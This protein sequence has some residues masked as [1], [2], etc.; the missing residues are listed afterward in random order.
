MPAEVRLYVKTAL[1]CFA[2]SMILGAGMVAAR[3]LAGAA[4]PHSLIVVHTHLALVGGMLLMVMGVA[5]WMFPLNRDAF[6]ETKG[7]WRPLLVQAVYGLVVG[8]LALRAVVEPLQAERTGG[9]LG[10]LLV[11]AAGLQVGGMLL[12]VVAI[13][14]R[15]RSVYTP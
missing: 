8:G 10:G 14:P 5:F 4:V 1:A 12:F 6:P 2:L 13:L 7:R 9:L 15:I 11:L 3:Q